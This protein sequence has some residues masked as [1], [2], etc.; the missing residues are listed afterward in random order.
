MNRLVG[1]AL[2]PWPCWGPKGGGGGKDT[3]IISTLFWFSVSH[4]VKKKLSE[5]VLKIHV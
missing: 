3:P 2:W 4:F 1:Q 5:T